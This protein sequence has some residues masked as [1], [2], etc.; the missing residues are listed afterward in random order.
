[1]ELPLDLQTAS[2]D[3]LGAEAQGDLERAITLYRQLDS[4]RELSPWA[5]WAVTRI[6]LRRGKNALP[7]WI[8][9]L[10][11]GDLEARSPEGTPVRLLA[12]AY[13]AQLPAQERAGVHAFLQSTLAELY[14]GRWWLTFQQRKIYASE[15]VSALTQPGTA[16]DVDSRLDQIE[17]VERLVRRTG[18]FRQDRS[19]R[20]TGN[21]GSAPVLLIVGPHCELSPEK[22]S[23]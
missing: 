18:T 12:A 16:P 5:Q 11:P 22:R 6:H 19:T 1:M 3:A 15:L 20:L 17:L 9:A 10:R 2:D 8:A 4:R 23:G 21:E 7:S 13:A 14:M